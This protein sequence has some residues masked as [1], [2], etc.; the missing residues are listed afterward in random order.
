MYNNISNCVSHFCAKDIEA[1]DNYMNRW[2]SSMDK[3]VG[4]SD[5]D[6]NKL[7]TYK[8]FKSDF[9]TEEYLNKI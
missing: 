6:R 3:S 5:R 2:F 8:R 1:N 4:Y 9:Q 7:R